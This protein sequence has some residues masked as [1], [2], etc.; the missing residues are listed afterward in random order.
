MRKWFINVAISFNGMISKRGEAVN[1][2][3]EDD[4]KIV[5]AFRNEIGGIVVGANTINV[6]NPSL[7][8][9]S[10]FLAEIVTVQ[11]PYRF[12]LDRRGLVDQ[13]SKVFQDQEL[14]K[15]FWYTR[16]GDDL[17]NGNKVFIEDD[18]IL[19]LKNS[20]NAV[21]DDNQKSG[22]IMVE[23]GSNTIRRFVNFLCSDQQLS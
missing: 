7:M 1:I 15:T 2:S 11:H 13:S 9:R 12:I 21:L 23:G 16:S 22:D 14:T 18:D 20:I 10:E 17:L 19:W 4:W 6:D 3:N 8:T 5:H